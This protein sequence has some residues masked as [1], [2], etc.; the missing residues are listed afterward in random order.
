MVSRSLRYYLTPYVVAIG[1]LT[2]LDVA[3]GQVIVRT[4]ERQQS[5]VMDVSAWPPTLAYAWDKV[6]LLESTDALQVAEIRERV[7]Q[8]L[9]G[10]GALDQAAAA[11]KRLS[12]LGYYSALA[13]VAKASEGAKRKGFRAEAERGFDFLSHRNQEQLVSELVP[14]TLPEGWEAVHAMISRCLDVEARLVALGRAA[15]TAAPVDPMIFER[16]L[17]MIEEATGSLNRLGRRYAAMAMTEAA[18]SLVSVGK[19]PDGLQGD[20]WSEI[21]QSAAD[22]AAGAPNAEAIYAEL[23]GVFLKRGKLEQANVLFEKAMAPFEQMGP[24]NPERMELM[25]AVTAL[26]KEFQDGR[27]PEGWA[28]QVQEEAEL[29]DDEWKWEVMILAGRT[30]VACDQNE[31]AMKCWKTAVMLAGKTPN[32]VVVSVCLAMLALEAHET[33]PDAKLERLQEWEVEVKTSS[34]T[35]VE[36]LK[37]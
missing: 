23:A 5:E 16:C 8:G 20:R 28:R 3:G 2:L 26:A 30:L 18:K 33:G 13:R 9:I 1:C 15:A 21:A 14:L 36:D 32:S 27:L 6:A 12:G 10:L 29:A 17:A 19:L 35:L 7:V 22:L 25:Q 34:K 11:A 4:P 31:Q 24:S 37:Q